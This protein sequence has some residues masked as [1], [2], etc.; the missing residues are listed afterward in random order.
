MQHIEMTRGRLY[1]TRLAKEGGWVMALI[2]QAKPVGS[3]FKSQLIGGLLVFLASCA[4]S[5]M[6]QAQSAAAGSFV[7]SKLL[8]FGKTFALHV[9]EHLA[10]GGV[11]EGVKQIV[12]PEPPDKAAGGSN[13]IVIAPGANIF[14]T[15]PSTTNA[16]LQGTCVGTEL[17]KLYASP[18]RTRLEDLSQKWNPKFGCDQATDPTQL[19]GRAVNL[20]NG[21]GV[22]TREPARAVACYEFAA[23]RGI[24]LAQYRLAGIYETGDEGVPPDPSRSRYWLNEAAARNFALAQT[25]LAIHLENEGNGA[26]A[27]H[28]YESAAA[29]GEPYA[30]YELS[31]IYHNGEYGVLPNLQAAFTCLY[32]SLQLGELDSPDLVEIRQQAMRHLL[33]SEILPDAQAGHP[34]AQSI[35]A[36]AYENG[37]AKVLDR[38]LPLALCWYDRAAAELPEVQAAINQ[39]CH[40]DYPRSCPFAPAR[41]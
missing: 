19:L 18:P 29:A 41:C 4:F 1:E 34:I 8:P 20:D 27:L 24:P 40:Y 21:I 14:N 30:L 6:A 37:I 35:V 23:A 22:P 17:S 5:T 28:W 16:C 32:L 10:A 12:T 15:A 3:G 38:H 39:F 26:T 2:I 7:A 33:F 11:V 25:Q 9:M 13:T 36:V 31:R